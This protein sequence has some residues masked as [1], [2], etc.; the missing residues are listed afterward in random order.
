[1]L[2]TVNPMLPRLREG[3]SLTLGLFVKFMEGSGVEVI[4]PVGKKFDPEIHEAV[5]AQ[6]VPG[7]SHDQ[8][9]TVVQKGYMLN[10]R[11]LRPAK[12][13]VSG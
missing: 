4:N 12:V 13:I 7:I 10:G 8:V 9:V 2:A 6:P 11:L 5:S 3:M 1:M